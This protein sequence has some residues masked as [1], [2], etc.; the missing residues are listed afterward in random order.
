MAL[1]SLASKP[2]LAPASL[3]L[4]LT[5][6]TSNL[7]RFSDY[8][9]FQL[10]ADEREALKSQSVIS[11]SGS[12]ASNSIAWTGRNLRSVPNATATRTLR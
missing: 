3:S 9:M 6:C 4:R 5:A 7:G 8:F 12:L 1:H 10:D 11:N 2:W